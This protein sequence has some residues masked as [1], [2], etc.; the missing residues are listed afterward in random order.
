MNEIIQ[1]KCPFDGAILSVKN[2]VGI[3]TKKVTCPVC[4]H[5]YPFTEY[6]IVKSNHYNDDKDTDYPGE[7][8]TEYAYGN[9]KDEVTELP[10]MNLTI[11]RLKLIGTGISYQLK[12]GRNVIGR[13]SAKS[14]ADFQIDTGDKRFMS[15]EHII[16]NVNKTPGKGFVHYISMFK[17]KEN[18]T[19]V[20]NEPLL[21][22]DCVILSH[23]DV[24]KLPDATLKFELPDDDCTEI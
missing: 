17:E 7:E 10:N 5:T 20:G 16:I 11:G 22:G 23:G 9:K 6:K 3:E 12:P 13:Q 19:F 24:I 8:K 18:K 4:K 14:T 21:F 1:I 15:R 2:Q